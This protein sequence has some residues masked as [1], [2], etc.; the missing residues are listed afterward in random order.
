VADG[1]PVNKEL[2]PCGQGGIS[3]MAAFSDCF[4]EFVR[5][6]GRNVDVEAVEDKQD[7]GGNH[8]DGRQ[9]KLV[10]SA[11]LGHS[12]RAYKGLLGFIAGTYKTP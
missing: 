5:N 3:I 2:R 4:L 7:Q 9:E 1:C 8:D 11:V 6:Q 10:C 12:L